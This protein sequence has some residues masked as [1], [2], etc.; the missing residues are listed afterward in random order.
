MTLNELDENHRFYERLFEVHRAALHSADITRQLLAFAGNQTGSPK[1]L[2]LNETI[3]AALKML[4]RLIGENIDLI[5]IPAVDLWQVKMDATQI[6]QILTN[7]AVNARDAINDA[8][9]LII[10]T[11]NITL[12]QTACATQD[13]FIP[14]DYV[15]MTVTDDGCG[16]D[17]D[18]LA[19]IFEPFFTTKQVGLGTGLGLATVYGIVKRKRGI[20]DVQSQPGVGTTFKIYLPRKRQA[21]IE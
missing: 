15:L 21:R 5:W 6:G 1:I 14:G 12:D 3:A 2:D 13:G 4:R 18:T 11:D 17:A 7:L 8:G 9:Q 16:M 19:M 10:T 20:I